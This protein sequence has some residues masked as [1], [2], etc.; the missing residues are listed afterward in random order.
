MASY[1]VYRPTTEIYGC[2]NKRMETFNEKA[3]VMDRLWFYRNEL[4]FSQPSQD[5][6]EIMKPLVKCY[7]EAIEKGFVV[8]AAVVKADEVNDLIPL[9]NSV[10]VAWYK[11]DNGRVS[12]FNEDAFASTTVIGDLFVGDDGKFYIA[13]FH[14]VV[15][16]E[17]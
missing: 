14:E 11:R 16:V 10:E 2:I 17:I 8:V 6:S 7:I 1:K 13:D 3:H 5:R 12:C 4:D 15:A 9:T